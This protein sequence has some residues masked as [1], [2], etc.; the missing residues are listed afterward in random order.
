MQVVLPPTV[1]KTRKRRTVKH[2]YVALDHVTIEPGPNYCDW[3][4]LTRHK[5]KERER[6]LLNVKRHQIESIMNLK[7]IPYTN[8]FKFTVPSAITDTTLRLLY[9]KIDTWQG[10]EI[11]RLKV[12]ITL[13][14]DYFD[15]AKKWWDQ[16]KNSILGDAFW[17]PIFNQTQHFVY[18]SSIRYL[19]ILHA[20]VHGEVKYNNTRLQPLVSGRTVMKS[21]QIHR[22]LLS[23][24]SSLNIEEWMKEQMANSGKYSA[25]KLM[26]KLRAELDVVCG[27][28]RD[29][30]KA[31]DRGNDARN[32]V[33]HWNSDV[34]GTSH[35]ISESVH[36]RIFV[37]VYVYRREWTHKCNGC[38]E[39]RSTTD[40]ADAVRWAKRNIIRRVRCT[41]FTGC[42]RGSLCSDSRIST[43]LCEWESESECDTELC[44]Y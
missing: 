7:L 6:N 28:S 41:T 20:F 1:I 44:H 33:N 22:H 29:E 21:T 26:T 27:S 3:I 39:D 13:Y 30:T 42:T 37:F 5:L 23:V 32:S 25:R 31:L 40:C 43:V 4:Q 16:V 36:E 8:R 17:V 10:V 9:E 12:S 19:H 38:N 2:G 24:H 35:I 14:R 15:K 34:L 18:G 11:A